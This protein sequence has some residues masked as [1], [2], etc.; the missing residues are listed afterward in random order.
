MFGNRVMVFDHHLTNMFAV[1]ILGDNA[2]I[3]HTNN[4]GQMESGTSL[5]FKYFR[6][7]ASYNEYYDDTFHFKGMEFERI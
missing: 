3:I 7:D 2:H 6:G 5:L 1:D 4:D